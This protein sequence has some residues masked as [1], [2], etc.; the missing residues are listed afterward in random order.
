MLSQFSFK[1]ESPNSDSQI[2]SFKGYLDETAEL[3]SYESLSKLKSLVLNLD[4]CRVINSSGIKKWVQLMT[5]LALKNDLKIVL[6]NCHPL[7][8][9]QINLI[10]GFL[11]Q[12]AEVESLYIMLFCE[13]CEKEFDVLKKVKDVETGLGAAIRDLKELDCEKFPECR[14]FITLD[15]HPDKALSFLKKGKEGK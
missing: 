3:P 9:D 15:M 10:E 5:Q 14:K 6:Q 1:V 12:N 7:I 2:I 8:L 11:P 13:K 4:G